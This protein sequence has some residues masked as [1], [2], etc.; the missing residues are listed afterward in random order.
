MPT[1]ETKEMARTPD[2]YPEEYQKAK[3][4]YYYFGH[5]KCA[6]HWIRHFLLGL[7]KRREMNYLVYRGNNRTN[8]FDSKREATFH[9]YVNSDPVTTQY[10]R[11]GSLGFHLIRDPRDVL[12]STYWSWRNTHPLIGLLTADMRHELKESGLEDGIRQ[13]LYTCVFFTQVRNWKLGTNPNILDV[14]YEELVDDEFQQFKRIVE[15]L[16]IDVD[17]ETLTAIVENCSFSK[18][19]KGRKRGEENV[20]SHYRKGISGDWK[21]YFGAD[22][23]VKEEIYSH[24]GDL[25]DNL[26]YER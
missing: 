10:M 8:D 9:L 19:A 25:I 7:S 1:K 17:R 11:Q 21:N 5:H 12:I 13:V 20:D 18:L 6:T 3:N 2:E 22:S 26:G 24:I 14:R 23:E 16:Q 15:F 4:N